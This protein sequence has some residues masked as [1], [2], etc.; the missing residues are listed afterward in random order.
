MELG[1]GANSA[2]DTMYSFIVNRSRVHVSV[3][4]GKNDDDVKVVVLQNVESDSIVRG[5]ANLGAGDDRFRGE[6]DVAIFDLRDLDGGNSTVMDFEVDGGAGD[7]ALEI[8][9]VVNGSPTSGMVIL[10]GNFFVR[11]RGG[12]GDDVL[13]FDWSAFVL[14]SAIGPAVQHECLVHFDGG[15]GDDV[16]TF[17]GG[18]DAGGAPYDGQLDVQLRG[19]LDNDTLELLGNFTGATFGKAGFMLVDGGGGG[20]DAG[21][22][23]GR[24]PA[25]VRNCEK[26]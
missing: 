9:R 26:P 12:D 2:A 25:R 11:F 1:A 16:L 7:D 18:D 17:I 3:N 13:D 24:G 20:A 4:G 21:V 15:R 10:E 5:R 22:A 6:F 19:G 8:S 14:S 23:Y